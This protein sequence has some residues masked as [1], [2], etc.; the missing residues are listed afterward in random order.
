MPSGPVPQANQARAA[1]YKYTANMRN[2]PAQNVAM[3]PQAAPVQAIAVKGKCDCGS[4]LILFIH[5]TFMGYF[6][7]TDNVSFLFFSR[8][9]HRSRTIDSIYVGCCTTSR[10]EANAW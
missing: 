1:N 10:T 2:P 4:F 7:I 8:L 3:V 6:F 9:N 5:R